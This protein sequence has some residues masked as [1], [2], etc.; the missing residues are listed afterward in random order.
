MG[1]GKF[2]MSADGELERRKARKL[3]GPDSQAVRTDRES[4][5]HALR[6]HALG[7]SFSWV[8]VRE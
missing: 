5:H 2:L 1:A 6:E 7:Q 4:A 3:E 8:E